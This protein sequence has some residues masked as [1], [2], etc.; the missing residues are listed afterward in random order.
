ALVAGPVW[1]QDHLGTFKFG[2]TVPVVFTTYGASD[3]SITMSGLAAT[4]I[5][6]YKRASITQRASDSGYA[7]IDTDGIDIDSV[8]GLPCFSIDTSDDTTSGFWEPG[9]S[10]TVVV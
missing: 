6:I 10:Y 2:E 3:E 7:L 9:G 1:A 4:D 5:E 8:T